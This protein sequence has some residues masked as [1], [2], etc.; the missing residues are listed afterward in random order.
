MTQIRPDS[1]YYL[2]CKKN[3]SL[4]APNIISI[5]A[6]APVFDLCTVAEMNIGLSVILKP[7][8]HLVQI[9]FFLKNQ[10]ITYCSYYQYHKSIYKWK[11]SNGN[12]TLPLWTLSIFNQLKGCLVVISF[13]TMTNLTMGKRKWKLSFKNSICQWHGLKKV[14]ISPVE[15]LW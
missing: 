8:M 7:K 9:Q 13:F 11:K 12:Y 6:N 15:N 10:T 14:W 2:L 1:V 4:Q 5:N 3:T